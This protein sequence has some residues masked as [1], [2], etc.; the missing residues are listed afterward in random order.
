MLFVDCYS[1]T[2]RKRSRCCGYVG[3]TGSNRLNCTIRNRCGSLC[4][5]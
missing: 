5:T 2:S 4:I 3:S 1:Y